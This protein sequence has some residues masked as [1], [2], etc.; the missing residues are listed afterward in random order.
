MW[1]VGGRSCGEMIIYEHLTVSERILQYKGTVWDDC[2]WH[3]LALTLVTLGIHNVFWCK[4][5]GD[6]PSTKLKRRD[7]SDDHTHRCRS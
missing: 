4:E 5:I 7:L 6:T 1:T 3:F 2:K